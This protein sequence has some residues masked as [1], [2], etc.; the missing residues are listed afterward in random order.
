MIHLDPSAGENE[1]LKINV[2]A[3]SLT[4]GVCK[5][6]ID[7]IFAI[8]MDPM[9]RISFIDCLKSMNQSEFSVNSLRILEEIFNFILNEVIKI[10]K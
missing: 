5:Q 2:L 8:L 4:N 6:N 3:K 9:N 10:Y 7:G 1:L